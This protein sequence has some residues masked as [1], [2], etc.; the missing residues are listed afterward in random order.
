MIN[1][2][3]HYTGFDEWNARLEGQGA[4]TTAELK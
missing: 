2:L 3:L 4:L 1:F